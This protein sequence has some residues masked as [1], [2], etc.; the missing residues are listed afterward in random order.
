MIVV[1]RKKIA[2]FGQ[3]WTNSTSSNFV[4]LHGIYE[5]KWLVV[6]S[7]HIIPSADFFPFRFVLFCCVG[8]GS[9]RFDF[10][11]VLYCFGCAHF[12]EKTATANALFTYYIYYIFNTIINYMIA[13]T[14]ILC[15]RD[16]SGFDKRVRVRVRV[17][18]VKGSQL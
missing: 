14:C 5:K 10:C 3:I 6:V 2:S 12:A 9:V 18:L 4:T 13:N 1:R 15:M 11:Y 17:V 7:E 16:V 8:L